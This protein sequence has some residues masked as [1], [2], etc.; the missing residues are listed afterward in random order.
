MF[1]K[2]DPNKTYTKH[3]SDLPKKSS[4]KQVPL[5]KIITHEHRSEPT[6]VEQVYL[7]PPR[8]TWTLDGSLD[9]DIPINISFLEGILIWPD[10]LL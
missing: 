5:K 6:A 9:S 4:H 3:K 7:S 10:L 2:G 1:L 8:G